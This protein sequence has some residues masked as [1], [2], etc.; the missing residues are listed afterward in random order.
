MLVISSA[1]KKNKIEYLLAKKKNIYLQTRK[2][3]C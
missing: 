3:A 1:I 2:N